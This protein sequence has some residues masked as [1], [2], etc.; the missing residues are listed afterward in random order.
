MSDDPRSHDPFSYL[1]EHSRERVRYKVAAQRVVAA[2]VMG[3]TKT[4]EQILKEQGYSNE[5]EYWNA[6][7]SQTTMKASSFARLLIGFHLDPSNNLCNQDL[8]YLN[9]MQALRDALGTGQPWFIRDPKAPDG[10]PNDLDRLRVDPRTAAEWLLSLPTEKGL[11]PP[12]LRGFLHPETPSKSA[13]KIADE[14]ECRNN[15]LQ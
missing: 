9:A 5:N 13:L 11:V 8:L 6:A 14:S 7:M 1:P 4:D 10:A 15:S 2:R 12:G 3:S